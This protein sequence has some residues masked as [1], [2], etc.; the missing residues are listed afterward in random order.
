M[1]PI[2][3]AGL[4][5]IWGA[6]GP[7]TIY[8]ALESGMSFGD[9]YTAIS[10]YIENPNTADIRSEWRSSWK[11]LTIEPMF[12]ML[13][14]DSLVPENLFRERSFI[15]NDVYAYRVHIY[16]RDLETGRYR[17][18]EAFLSSSNILTPNEA[19]DI[20]RSRVGAEGDSP[21]YDI[22]SMEVRGAFT[23]PGFEEEW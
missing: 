15:Q 2:I 20:M 1:S 11:S 13:D 14:P 8:Q 5:S 7:N 10:P 9:F 23:R 19:T 21:T 17:S 3:L 18:E 22:Y 4:E 6:F 12:K 16:G